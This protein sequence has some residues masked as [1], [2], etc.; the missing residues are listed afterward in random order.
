MKIAVC[1]VGVTRNYSKYTLDSIQKNLFGVVAKH[2]PNFK[3]FAHFNKLDVLTNQRSREHGVN[4]D[5]EEYKLLN[6]DVVEL[7]DQSL[8][9][10]RIDFDYLQQFGNA[11]KDNFG[12]L[13]NV[14][15]QMYSLNCVADILERQNTKFDLVIWS[16][17]CLRF[18]KPIEIPRKIQPGTLYTPWFERFR[19]LNDRFSLGDMPTMLSVFRRQSAVRD[20]V[21][22]TGRPLGAESYLLWYAKKKGL[23]TRHLT[24]MNFSRI[25]A[26]GTEKLIKDD[27]PEKLKYY[28]KHGLELTGLR[29]IHAPSRRDRERLS[30]SSP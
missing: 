5:P 14:L 11:F 15:R 3:R 28:I 29:N 17:V 27:L 9:D 26:D 13:K 20:F 8:V 1:F 19:G 25:R 24:K 23:H 2:D 16:R 22:E 4:I 21:H 7:T 30:N 10:Q 18:Y 6:C 12:T